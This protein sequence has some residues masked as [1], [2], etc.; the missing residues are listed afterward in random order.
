MKLKRSVLVEKRLA[1]LFK[2]LVQSEKVVL[3]TF[4]I[5]K[6]LK[7]ERNKLKQLYLKF[8]E[9]KNK[10]FSR[11]FNLYVDFIK[12]TCLIQQKKITA[13]TLLSTL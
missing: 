5:N 11:R 1:F 7:Q 4:V 6:E 13:S 12:L 9:Y 3:K 2:N 8:R 10:L